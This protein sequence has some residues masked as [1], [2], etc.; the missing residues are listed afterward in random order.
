MY[1]W[2]LPF[3]IVEM[4]FVAFFARLNVRFHMFF[5]FFNYP[6]TVFYIMSHYLTYSGK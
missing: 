2:E 3:F 6:L 5:F 4:A 1:K